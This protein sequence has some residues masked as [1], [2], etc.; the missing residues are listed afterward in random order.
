MEAMRFSFFL[1]AQTKEIIGDYRVE[2]VLLKDGRIV[3]G[4]MV[5]VSAGVKPNIELAKALGIELE[6][7]IT[8]NER[9]ESMKNSVYAAGDVAQFKGR[10]F[11]IW[12]AAQRQGEIAGINMAGGDAIYEGTVISNTLKV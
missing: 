4:E 7:G 1:N 8:V 3:N 10:C 2:G 9:L 5:I 12:P 6:N 11:G